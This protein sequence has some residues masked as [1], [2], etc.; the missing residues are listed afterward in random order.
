L[1]ISDNGAPHHLL[2]CEVLPEGGLGVPRRLF[3]GTPGHPDGVKVDGSGRIYVSAAQGVQVIGPNGALVDEIELP[4]TVIFAFGDNTLF[5]TAD[6][7]I[8]AAKGT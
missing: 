8:W 2:V 5:I 7:A 1:Y 6:T 3:V 4:G